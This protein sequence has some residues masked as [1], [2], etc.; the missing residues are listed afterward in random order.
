MLASTLRAMSEG[1]ISLD[2]TETIT[3]FNPAA[4]A[5]TGWSSAEAMGRPVEEI[6]RLVDSV[7]GEKVDTAFVA[8]ADRRDAAKN[9]PQARCSCTRSG[10]KRPI[11]GSIAP[12]RDHQGEIAGAV[13]VFGRASG[14]QG[15]C[16]LA[17]G[18]R[19]ARR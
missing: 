2:Q 18:P 19:T 11:T 7:A 6:F 4:E 17:H 5:W 10:E 15:D 12:V 8:C 16:T 1:V 9:C 14:I 13:L 3:L